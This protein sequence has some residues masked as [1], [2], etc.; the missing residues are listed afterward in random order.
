MQGECQRTWLVH[1][2]Q[3]RERTMANSNAQSSPGSVLADRG[4]Q[5]ASLQI[6]RPKSRRVNSLSPTVARSTAADGTL[7]PTSRLLGTRRDKSD[8]HNIFLHLFLPLLQRVD[9]DL[10]LL[11]V[12]PMHGFG[13][14][15]Q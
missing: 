8:L 4:C 11:G 5:P 15:P 9:H 1:R 7:F 13:I 6:N 12:C 14:V 10:C 2:H 3:L